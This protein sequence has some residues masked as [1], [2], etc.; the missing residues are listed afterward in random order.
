MSPTIVA[1][2]EIPIQDDFDLQKWLK[3]IENAEDLMSE[4]EAKA[5]NLQAK[6]DALLLEVNQKKQEVTENQE[7]AKK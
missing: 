6:V 7:Q 4:V 1:S 3:E 2:D 5:D